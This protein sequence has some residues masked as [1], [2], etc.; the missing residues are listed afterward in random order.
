MFHN[1]DMYICNTLTD[2]R[3]ENLQDFA[4]KYT[5]HACWSSPIRDSE[6]KAIGSF[7]LSSFAKR[8]PDNFQ[9]RIL[10]SCASIA[11]IIMQREN[12][13]KAQHTEHKVLL[14]SQQQYRSLVDNSADSIFLH[15]DAGYILDVNQ[16]ACDSL[17][18]TRDELLSIQITDIEKGLPD[19]VSFKENSESLN[20]DETHTISG[21]HQSK[22][23]KQFPVEVRIRRYLANDQ[24]LTVALVRNITDRIKEEER[25]AIARKLESIGLLAGGIAHDFNNMLGVIQGYIDLASRNTHTPE[26]TEGYLN[27]ASRASIQATEL[28]QQ[29]LTFA[30]G[31]ELIKQASNIIE[32]IHQSTDFNLHGSN[33]KATYCQLCTDD[34]W[35]ANID[36][37]QISQVIQ[38]LVI[39]ARESMPDGGHLNITYENCV[40]TKAENTKNFQHEKFIK[41]TLRDTGTGIPLNIINSIFDP[42]FTTKQKGNGLGLALSYSIV[43]KH[44]GY[45]AVDSTP[46]QGTCFT[47][48]LPASNEQPRTSS[49]PTPVSNKT[50]D[51]RILIMDD[52]DMLREVT[53]EMLQNLGYTVILSTDAHTAFSQYEK[54][55]ETQDRIDL[56]IMDLT[57][58]NGIGGKEAIKLIQKIDPKVKALVSSGYCNDPVMANHHDYG[59]TGALKKPYSQ[60]ELGAAI[61]IILNNKG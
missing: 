45:I 27:K 60:D 44:E 57:I 7:A 36:S 47:L 5:L 34:I 59:F 10:N 32:I 58:P 42:Y 40:I 13:L 14:D 51:A 35:A 23:G 9:R 4:E 29:L 48:Y 54:A 50:T 41:I 37:G 21:I 17:G 43:N 20:L 19:N 49:T 22:D 24:F 53:E 2:A 16:M 1:E 33:I 31:G 15:N 11:G 55:M 25:A 61:D 12:T 28:T 3:W 56:V 30:K 38:N 6:N 52:D 18:Y 39:N 46:E 8:T 26:K